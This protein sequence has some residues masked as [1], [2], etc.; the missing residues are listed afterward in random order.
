MLLY[1]QVIGLLRTVFLYRWV[2][3]LFWV[4][5]TYFW[6]TKTCVIAAIYGSP[7]CELFS[8]VGHPL[9]QMLR[10]TGLEQS[11]TITSDTPCLQTYVAISLKI[12]QSQNI[13]PFD[14]FVLK[15]IVFSGLK[16]LELV[17]QQEDWWKQQQRIK[18]QH[19]EVLKLFFSSA[20]I[21]MKLRRRI[22]SINPFL[23]VR[24][25]EAARPHQ[26]QQQQQQHNNNFVSDNETQLHE[27]RKR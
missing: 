5:G 21:S 6:V 16:R 4:A 3:T 10:T 2:A 7:K 24:R 1:F 17:K 8:F 22:T 13:F 18:C 26:Q 23:W 25:L 9:Y 27:K 14:F 15:L 11:N 19:F 20:A 12:S